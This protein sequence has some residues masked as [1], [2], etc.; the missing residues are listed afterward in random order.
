M[1]AGRAVQ[2]HVITYLEFVGTG[3]KGRESAGF[4]RRG[5]STYARGRRRYKRDK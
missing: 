4:P 1:D 5:P 2:L 3:T